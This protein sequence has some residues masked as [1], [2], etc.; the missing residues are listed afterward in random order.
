MSQLGHERQIRTVC[1]ITAFT[2][3]SRR[4]SGH[5]FAP[6]GAKS[7][8]EQVQQTAL[9]DHPVGAREQG[10]RHLETERL[11]GLKIDDQLELGRL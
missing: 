7:C 10:R 5:R 8:R 6:F 3:R 4:K 1:N 11:G 9:F 2:P